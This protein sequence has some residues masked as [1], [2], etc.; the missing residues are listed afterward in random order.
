[1]TVSLPRKIIAFT[2]LL[3]L[4]F[5][6]GST[7]AANSSF[8]QRADV[9]QFI[10]KMVSQ[11][12]FE[13]EPLT[14]LLSE[15]K[16]SEAVINAISRPY[17]GKPWYQY[18]PIFVTEKRIKRGLQFWQENSAALQRAEKKY[19]VP[20]EFITA[21]I[22]VESFY[23]VH[24]GNYRLLDSL[25]TLGF[26]YPRRGKFFRSELKHYLL[27]TREEKIDPRSVKG[28]YAGAMGKPQFIASSYREYAVDF[29]G[30]GKRDLW[31][32]TEDAI[33]SVAN[34]FRRHGWKHGALVASRASVKGSDYQQL[35]KKS[36]KPK[37]TL[38]QITSLGVTLEDAQSNDI[39]SDTK[40]T[41]IRLKNQ[42]ESE[43]WVIYRNFYA[44]SRY[45][46]SAL[47]SMAI[48]QIASALREQHTAAN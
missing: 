10:D 14:Q 41:L 31:E 39:P 24:K 42:S 13:R 46:H 47:Y 37:K 8:T 11:H 23:G 3:I 36:L 12:Q 15:A 33:G 35:I 19:G 20:P 21:I 5:T 25:T 4:L 7:L 1:M 28:S 9:Q 18:R 43:Y 16:H 2:S 34:Y 26:D 29:S 45:N 44:I 38:A 27:M 30:D 32:N 17:E 48:F 6:A 22:G 40:A